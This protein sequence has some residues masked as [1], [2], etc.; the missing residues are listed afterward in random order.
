MESLWSAVILGIVEGLTEFLPV[1]STGHL[2]LANRLLGLT[3]EKIATFDVVIQLGAILAVV[4]LYWPRFWGLLRSDTRKPFSGMRGL[5]M[6]A[7]TTLPAVV[8][9]L[10]LHKYIKA[11]L[12]GPATVAWSMGVGAVLIL[13]VEALRLRPRVFSLDQLTPAQAF[14]IGCFQCIAMWPGFSRSAAT[15]LGGMVLGASREAATE[16]SFIAAVPI[17]V[18]AT[19]LDLVKSLKDFSTGDLEFLAVGFVVSFIFAWLAVKGFITLLK[20]STL[21]PFAYYRLVLAP[22]VFFLWPTN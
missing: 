7:I 4:V 22:V 11:H 16:Y 15:I 17:M 8:L 10:L 13:V 20:S 12:F 14:G 9:G 18:G 3:G 5:Y 19:G 6:L 1:S 21:R 2:I